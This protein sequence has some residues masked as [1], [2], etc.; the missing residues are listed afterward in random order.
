MTQNRL[1]RAVAQATGETICTI[2]RR[3]FGM[4]DPDFV[5]YDPE[6]REPIDAEDKILDWDVLDA[7]RNAVLV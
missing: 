4:A 5:E 3:G 7:E 1:N 6:P 2:S